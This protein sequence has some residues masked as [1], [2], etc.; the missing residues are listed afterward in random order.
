MIE[1]ELNWR[2]RVYARRALIGFAAGL[3]LFGMI[4]IFGRD[5]DI[6]AGLV[7]IVGGMTLLGIGKFSPLPE[8]P[9]RREL[10]DD[11]E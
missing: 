10:G 1:D 11:D 2:M 3:V 8:P 6:T 9:S 7:I 5:V 4:L